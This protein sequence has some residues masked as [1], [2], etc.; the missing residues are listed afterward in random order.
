MLV[1]LTTSMLA[2]F[3]VVVAYQVF[4]RYVDFVP[5]F[6]WT[7]EISRFSFIWMLFLGTAVAVRKK[8]HFVIDLFPAHIQERYGRLLDLFVLLIILA[9]AVSMVVGGVHFVEMG[10]KRISTTSG[11]QLAWIYLS[12][13]VSGASII[14]F[15]LEQLWDILKK[16]HLY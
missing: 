12:I 3:T 15:S 5:R 7:E 4:S 2:L 14:L 9:V 13:P 11:I 1:A 10:L 6:I 8:R 16:R